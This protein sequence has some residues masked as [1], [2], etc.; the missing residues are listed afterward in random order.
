LL[1]SAAN[2]IRS[3]YVADFNATKYCEWLHSVLGPLIAGFRRAEEKRTQEAATEDEKRTT[4]QRP[5]GRYVQP[6]SQRIAASRFRVARQLSF[7]RQVVPL[8]SRM[9]MCQSTLVEGCS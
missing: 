1:V 2:A 6:S 7:C 8:Y 4:Y 9:P 5:S 3:S